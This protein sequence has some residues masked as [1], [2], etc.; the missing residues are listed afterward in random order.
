MRVDVGEGKVWLQFGYHELA[1]SR[2][3]EQFLQVVLDSSGKPLKLFFSKKK[4]FI[5]EV[6]VT[7]FPIY[8]YKRYFTNRD[9]PVHVLYRISENGE[10][11]VVATVDAKGIHTGEV[12]LPPSILELLRTDWLEPGKFESLMM[13]QAREVE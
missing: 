12:P 4:P 11:K 5:V 6:E 13:E 2:R 7:K 8:F 3:T 10:V 1:S 9:Y